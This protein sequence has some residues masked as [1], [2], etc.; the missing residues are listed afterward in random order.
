MLGQKTEAMLGG[1]AMNRDWTE[2]LSCIG[3]WQREG[4]EGPCS[5]GSHSIRA[6]RF[7]GAGDF[8]KR[9]RQGTNVHRLSAQT[10]PASGIRVGIVSGQC[11]L[12]V[13]AEAQHLPLRLNLIFVGHPVIECHTSS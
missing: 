7:Q 11:L 3:K 2:L 13:L 8:Q 5:L 10:W 12:A 9:V 4:E 6:T 1:E